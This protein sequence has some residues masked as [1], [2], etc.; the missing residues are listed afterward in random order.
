MYIQYIFKSNKP[1][2]SLGNYITVSQLLVNGLLQIVILSAL[3]HSVAKYNSSCAQYA[4]IATKLL[5]MKVS[6]FGTDAEDDDEYDD[7]EDDDD[8]DA[9]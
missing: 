7:D 3:R 1:F 6:R 8:N 9:I 4:S 2:P 5:C